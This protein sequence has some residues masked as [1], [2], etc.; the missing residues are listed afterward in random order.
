VVNLQDGYGR[1]ITNLR[2]SVT[3][4]CNFRCIYCMPADPVWLPQPQLLSFEEIE[5][6]VRVA[7][8]LGITDFRITGGEPTARKNLPELVRR[9]CA[10]PGVKDVGMTTNGLLLKNV[11]KALWDAGL[12]RLNISLDTLKGERFVHIARR[13]G[14]KQTWEGIEEADRVGFRPLKI[15][16]VVMR[17]MNEDEV[18]EFAGLA[19]TR[20]WRI[21]Y[22]EFMPLDG[23]GIWSRDKVVPAKEILDRIHARWP[24]E[25]VSDAPLTDPARVFRF[26]D[27]VGDVGVIASV[28]EPFCFACDR[29]RITPDGQ[30][31]TCLFSTWETDLKEPMRAGASD[32]ELAAL[33]RGAVTKKEAGHGINDPKFVKPARAMYAIGG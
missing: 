16:M 30:L 21:R 22:I 8:S 7:V 2:I 26:K 20:D 31:R 32:A 23:D 18:V 4:R 6:L 27:G 19:R 14:F 13:D 9:V 29:V 33:I 17:G 5:R 11:A 25:R 10:V 12:R 3:D 28:T 15:N 24:L 1:E